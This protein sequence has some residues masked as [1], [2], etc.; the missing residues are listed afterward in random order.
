M[1]S[2]PLPRRVGGD[3][4]QVHPAGAVLDEEQHIEA[5]K[6]HGIDVEEIRRQDR[7]GLGPQ[8][9]PPG[10]ADSPGRGVDARVFENLPHRRRRDLGPQPSQLTVDAPVTP[11]GSQ[12]SAT[13]PDLGFYAER[14]YSLTRPPTM[15]LRLI[16]SWERSAMG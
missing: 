15:G 7:P 16:R 8:E 3:P 11:A 2:H 10:L 9:R 4:G 6:Q 12:N 1:Y 13:G 14:S 5:A